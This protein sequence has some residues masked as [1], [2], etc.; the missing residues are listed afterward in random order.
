ME[1]EVDVSKILL[2]NGM[3]L[4]IKERCDS[5]A[6]QLSLKILKN[7]KTFPLN[8]ERLQN[9]IDKNIIEPIKVKQYKNTE[10]YEVIDGRHRYIYNLLNENKKI[11]VI[12]IDS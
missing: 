11:N 12:V 6:K 3:R 1:K 5:F 9:I 10:Y 8:D 2:D 7:D 4:K